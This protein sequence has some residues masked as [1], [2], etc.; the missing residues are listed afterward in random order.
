MDITAAKYVMDLLDFPSIIFYQ[1]PMSTYT[2]RQASRR[3]WRIPQKK[4][5]KG[6][7]PYLF[8]DHADKVDAAYGR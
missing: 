7:L 1:I 5:V 2:L 3:S 6:V 8:R 4:P